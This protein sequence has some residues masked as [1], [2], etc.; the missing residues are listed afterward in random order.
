LP[1][2]TSRDAEALSRFEREARAVAAISHPNIV[3]IHDV[4]REGNVSYAVVELLEGETLRERISRA[5]LPTR[6][7]LE[8]AAAIELVRRTRA[9]S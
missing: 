4:G 6:D 5:A 2:A 7:A 3:A 9:S 8:I 1:E